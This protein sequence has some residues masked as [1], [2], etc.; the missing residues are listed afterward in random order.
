MRK[1]YDIQDED[2]Y[3]TLD[4]SFNSVIAKVTLETE[5]NHIEELKANIYRNKNKY[6]KYLQIL[7]YKVKVVLVNSLIKIVLKKIFLTNGMRLAIDYFSAIIIGIFDALVMYLVIQRMKFIFESMHKVDVFFLEKEKLYRNSSQLF[8]EVLRVLSN[9]ISDV[10]KYHPN[11][12]YILNHYKENLCL[13]FSILDRNKLES[14][15]ELKYKILLLDEKE[16]EEIYSYI[17][18]ITR[19]N[20]KKS[21]DL[22]KF[23]YS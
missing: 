16:K 23:L 4:F 18:F 2:F 14:F 22:K 20:K 6:L 1:K 13:D 15:E 21:K 5:E 11:Y 9:I 8:K 17:D 19:L 3:E 12:K 10:G 7:F